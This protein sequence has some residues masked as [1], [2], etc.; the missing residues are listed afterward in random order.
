MNGELPTLEGL[1]AIPRPNW[2]EIDLDALVSNLERLKAS[3]NLRE[4]LLPVKADAYGH[5]A[6]AC[7]MA[8]QLTG[9]ATMLGAAHLFEALA[10]RQ[11]G[12]TMPVLVLGPA[13]KEELPFFVEHD[14]VPTIEDPALAEWFD[15]F[16]AEKGAT[17]PF[18]LKINTGMNRFGLPWDDAA[19]IRR[20]AALK[21]AK[22]DGVYSHLA[23]ADDPSSDF[24][25]EQ[26]RRFRAAVGA[27][28][29][30]PRL[31]HLA[32]SSGLL[33]FPGWDA[34]TM[35]R[36]G[37]ASYGASPLDG[38]TVD[39]FGL[40]PALRMYSTIRMVHTV[41]AGDSV[42]Y[43]LRWT[44]E[45][46]SR[47]A[48]V[49]IGY[50]DGFRR[51]PPKGSCVRIRGVDCPILGTVCMDVIMV[52]VSHLPEAAAGDT[53]ALI[54]AD[55]GLPLETIAARYNTIPYEISCD[56]ARRLYR[57]YRWKGERLNWDGL[58]AKF[59]D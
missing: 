52:D 7:S 23:V 58:C 45:K 40:R 31:V 25:E 28:P 59:K 34:V 43:G 22:I 18:H 3:A 51:N 33:R 37:L 29:E 48:L 8:C 20:F 36:P 16:L 10:L 1:S 24:T 13:S 15:G 35:A 9:A 44:A 17:A 30:R 21:H 46:D 49:A 26:Y 14:V 54:D 39:E 47:V 5:G 27:L 55:E 57:V 53:V 2:I 38:R 50:G 4:L 6:L 19:S 32:A 41:K 56:L 12:V 42:S 11:W